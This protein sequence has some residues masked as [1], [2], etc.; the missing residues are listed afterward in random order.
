MRMRRGNVQH[1]YG[2][3]LSI[4]GEIPKLRTMAEEL[5]YVPSAN[6]LSYNPLDSGRGELIVN[7][8]QP[9]LHSIMQKAERLSLEVRR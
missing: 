6:I 7:A 8:R 5:G 9:A 2:V 4:V 1:F 3:H